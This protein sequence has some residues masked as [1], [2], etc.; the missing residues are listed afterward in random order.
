MEEK[1]KTRTLTIM[2]MTLLLTIF[3]VNTVKAENQFIDISSNHGAFQEINFLLEKQVINGYLINGKK[4]FKP[5]E[6]VTR[7]QAAKMLINATGNSGLTVENSSFTDIK[8]S[9]EFSYYAERTFQLGWFQYTSER[10]FSPNMVVSRQEMAKII[11]KA[12]NYD[13]EKYKEMDLPFTDVPKNNM[14]YK[15]VAAV[16]YNG[17]AKGTTATMF[18]LTG[19]VTRSQ[20]ALFVSRATLDKF[21][22][23]LPQDVIQP[24]NPKSLGYI[25]ITTNGLNVRF[26]ADFNSSDNI[27]GRLNKGEKLEYYEVTPAYYKIIYNGQ[28]SFISSSYALILEKSDSN[29][30][31]IEPNTSNGDVKSSVTGIVTTKNLVIRAEKNNTSKKVASLE[32]GAKVS[33]EDIDGNWLKIDINGKKAYVEKTYIRLKNN[34]GSV[35]KNRII[36]ID[37]GHGGKDPG[38]VSNAAQEKQVTIGVSQ[39][40]KAF[41]EKQGAKVYMT[42]IGDSYPSLAERVNYAKSVNGEIYIS[43]HANSASASANGTETYYSVSNNLNELEDKALAQYINDE[44]VKDAEMRDRGVKRVDYFVIKNLAVP[45]VLV[46]LGFITNSSD[47]SKL[48][49]NEY[50][51]TFAQSIFN[52]IVKYYN[53]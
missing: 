27:I 17:I 50:Q 16:Y 8:T 35:L 2:I 20:F 26:T 52:G 33:V 3:A 23:P 45:A 49:S 40:L 14:Y 37:A 41:L 38:S 1:M 29:K 43:I 31:P 5:N 48:I 18:D 4:Y 15:Y 6:K 25:Q 53:R 42:R 39:K 10:N 19:G 11:S 24:E 47:Q 36:I 28:P 30:P 34:Q 13:L 44:I 12:Y 32:R 51:S 9:H 21:R 7:G 22:L 46:E